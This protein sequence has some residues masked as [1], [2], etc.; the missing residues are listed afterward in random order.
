MK[1]A[2]TR[3]VTKVSF[4]S[5]ETD[6]LG[7]EMKLT[8]NVPVIHLKVKVARNGQVSINDQRIA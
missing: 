2:T 5:F 8:G 1:T 6:K 3:P 4:L 7:G